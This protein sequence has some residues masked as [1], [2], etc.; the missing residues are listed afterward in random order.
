MT[1]NTNHVASRGSADWHSTL[2]GRWIELWNGDFEIADAIVDE[3]IV[4]H[5]PN[6][7]PIPGDRKQLVARIAAIHAAY[8]DIRIGVESGPLMSRNYVAGRWVATGANVPMTNGAD[9][10]RIESGRI[11]EHW[12][13]RDLPGVLLAGRPLAQAT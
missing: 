5:L 6:N 8:P 9:I 2:W 1:V 13:S 12:T 3:R 7:S 4:S 10:L 11:V